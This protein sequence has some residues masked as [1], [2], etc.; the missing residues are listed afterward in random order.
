[1]FYVKYL[2]VGQSR[3]ANDRASIVKHVKERDFAIAKR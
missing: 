2:D 1:M 3:Q